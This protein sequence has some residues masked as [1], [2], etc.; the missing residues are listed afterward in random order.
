MSHFTLC[1]LIWLF[2]P[3]VVCPQALAAVDPFWTWSGLSLFSH[4]SFVREAHFG[5]LMETDVSV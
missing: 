5:S 1:D 3:V 4:G 2:T